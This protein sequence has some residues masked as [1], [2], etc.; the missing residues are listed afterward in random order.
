M[1][2]DSY[3]KARLPQ[4]FSCSLLFIIM[5][6]AFAYKFD[7]VI[8]EGDDGKKVNTE[9]LSTVFYGVQIL[10]LFLKD[11]VEIIYPPLIG[12]LES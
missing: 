10:P 12:K 6:I 7:D 8:E 4:I 5:I 1:N 11:V 3:T 2:G 9:P